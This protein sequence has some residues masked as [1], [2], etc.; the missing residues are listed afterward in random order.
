MSDCITVTVLGTQGSA[1]REAG[2]SMRIW[3]DRQSGSIGG[4]AL[5]WQATAIARD[6]LATN[7]K[8]M[9]RSLTLGP[10]LGQCCGGVV[11]LSFA[12]AEIIPDHAEPPLWIW[13]GGHVGRAIAAT[14]AP[15]EDREIMLIDTAANRL[16]ADLPDNVAPLVASDPVRLVPRACQ[17]AA[18]LVL[19][20]SH[21]IDLMLCDALLHH[22]FSF[23]GLIGS[24]TKWARF[25]KRLET[26]GH[27]PA[28]IARITCPI[29][30]RSLGKH[31]QAIAIGVAASLITSQPM[32][33][34]R[35]RTA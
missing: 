21:E 26:M 4:G 27:M 14:M 19:T 11:E 2:A 34:R 7:R 10:D 12:R 29:G 22:G 13:G 24:A 17:Q 35:N 8:E 6:M 25:R 31:P 28:Q 32:D 9:Q 20:Y 3:A 33:A 15:F 18:H 30:D 1:P 5:E 16:P 23:A